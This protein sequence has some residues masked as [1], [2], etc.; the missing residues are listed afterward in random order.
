MAINAYH[1]KLYNVQF[2]YKYWNETA[3]IS[4]NYFNPIL[5]KYYKWKTGR[6][7][8]LRH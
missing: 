1:A 4:E 8:G 7:K 3:D 6:F 5:Q 2:V